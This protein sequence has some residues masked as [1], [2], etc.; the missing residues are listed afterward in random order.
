MIVGIQNFNYF[1]FFNNNLIFF[2]KQIKF[3][4]KYILAKFSYIYIKNFKNL[5]QSSLNN[6]IKIL[7]FNYY[8]IEI[9]NIENLS[10]FLVLDLNFNV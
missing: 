10:L 7:I 2:H 5:I 6:H 9:A 4:Y 3:R 8:F 1:Y